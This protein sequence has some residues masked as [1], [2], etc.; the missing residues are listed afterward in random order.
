MDQ[1]IKK[2]GWKIWLYLTP[3]YII[4]AIPLVKWTMKINSSDVDL[5]KDE[6][7]AFNSQEGE[8]KKNSAVVYSPDLDESGYSL[9]YISG[10]SAGTQKY[11]SGRKETADTK[12]QD[13]ARA[14]SAARTAE[15]KNTSGYQQQPLTPIQQREQQSFGFTKGY[16][17]YAIGKALNNPKAVSAI[18]NNK[19]VISGFMSRDTVKAATAS[20]E[21]LA[22]YL[23]TGNT[24]N[25]FMNNS[26]VQSALNNPQVLAAAASSGMLTALL[27]T[28]AGKSL[29]SNPSAM[30]DIVTSNPELTG[31]M[32]DPKIMGLLMSNPQASNYIGQMTLGGAGKK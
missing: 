25:T 6:Y 3:V 4:L 7:K 20:P 31:L 32:A 14:Q 28:P 10:H 12:Q 2:S 30:A 29:L 18:L 17:T 15:Q 1:E 9:H 24:V 13:T 8:I 11:A 19:Y 26:V 27:D 5:S 22:N 16:I 23:K 21:A